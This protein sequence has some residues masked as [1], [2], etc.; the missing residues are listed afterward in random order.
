MEPLLLCFSPT[1]KIPRSQRTN[2]ISGN[3]VPKEPPID[4][5]I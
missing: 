1:K 5:M 3:D 2:G 4:Q